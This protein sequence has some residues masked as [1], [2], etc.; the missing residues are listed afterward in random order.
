MR[1]QSPESM[2]GTQ[3]IARWLFEVPDAKLALYM[4]ML[5]LFIATS[6][7]FVDSRLL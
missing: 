4:L 5:A 1:N 3:R 2:E 6:L 7:Y